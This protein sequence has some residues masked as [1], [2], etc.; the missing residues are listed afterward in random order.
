[1]GWQGE[2]PGTDFRGG[3]LLSLEL[4]VHMAENDNAVFTALM[5]K[6]ELRSKELDYPFGAAGVNLTYMLTGTFVL[7]FKL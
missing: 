6:D 5:N 3:G 1:M 4:L 2:H 7:K